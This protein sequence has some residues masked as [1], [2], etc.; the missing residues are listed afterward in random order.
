MRVDLAQLV[1][2]VRRRDRRAF[3]ELHAHYAP[4]V[5]AIALSRLHP[6]EAEDVV[7]EVFAVA[8]EQLPRL[9]DPS[10]FGGWI[11]AIAR[12]KTADALRRPRHVQLDEVVVLD[13]PRLEAMEALQ[14]IRAL[15][16]AYRET[17][18]MRLVGGLTGPEIAQRTGLTPGSVRVN[19]H[20][21][22]ALLRARLGVAA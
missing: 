4:V 13:P 2:R 6:L 17:L 18:L 15:P 10:A 21:G 7:Q 9:R 12:S 19:L 11:C 1:R 14:A 22:M 3:A 16:P 5:H 8:L 20:R